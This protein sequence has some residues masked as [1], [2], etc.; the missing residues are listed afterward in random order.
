MSQVRTELRNILSET[1]HD[2]ISVQI[3]LQS[4]L[5][6]IV[7]SAVEISNPVICLVEHVLIVCMLRKSIGT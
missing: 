6:C 4:N 5:V 3:H 2:I 1:L 7:Q